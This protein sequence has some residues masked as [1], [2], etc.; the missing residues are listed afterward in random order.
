LEKRQPTYDLEALRAA[1]STV[2]GL[3]LTGA[4][5]R[6]AATL[7]FG[8]AEIVAIIQMMQRTQ[9]YKFGMIYVK[10][11][12]DA[13]SEFLLQSFKEKDDG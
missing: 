5:L 2:Q 11:T 12:A 7:G 8:R 6:G 9:F 13:V 10:F 4:A 3:R 1:F